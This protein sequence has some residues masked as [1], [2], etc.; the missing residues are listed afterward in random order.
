[1][2]RA[3]T[4]NEFVAREQDAG[5]G[6]GAAAAA[7][8]A[9]A[10]VAEGL[11]AG[12][13]LGADGKPAAAAPDKAAAPPAGEAYF[14]KG[15]DEK[16]KGKSD[17]ETLDNIAKAWGERPKAPE[18]PDGYKLELAPEVAARFGDLNA[19]PAFKVMAEVAHAAGVD[20]ALLGKLFV[21]T[22]QKLVDGGL[23]PKPI[24]WNAEALKLAPEGERDLAA[25]RKA[26]AARVTEIAAGVVGLEAL[27]NFGAEIVNKALRTI[28]EDAIGARMIEAFLSLRPKEHGVQPGAGG[29][30]NALGQP[31]GDEQASLNRMYPSMVK[32]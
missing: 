9:A 24:D 32:A 2:R 10:V 1:M 4:L 5:A 12:A 28:N 16:W 19:D 27:P 6:G 15:L 30:T 31:L 22:Y 20:N 26:A 18:K 7:P 8:A 11:L 29:I 14:P 25:G 13:G 17:R 21:G 3:W 23:M